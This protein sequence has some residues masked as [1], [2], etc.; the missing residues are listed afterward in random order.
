MSAPLLTPAQEVEALHRYQIGL[1]AGRKAR[2]LSSEKLAEKYGISSAAIDR[3][4]G[5]GIKYA[6]G[7]RAYQNTPHKVL[8]ELWADIKERDRQ[9]SICSANTVAVLAG[10][11]G[12][13]GFKMRSRMDYAAKKAA[14]A[15]RSPNRKVERFP[16]HWF[17]TM[18]A[19][20]PGVSAGYYCHG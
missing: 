2:K 12:V 10:E 5:Q 13:E 9:R 15:E 14:R 7:S 18:P 1:E 3:I 4:A 11:L 6:H 19:I 8:N 20:N 16:V 17:L